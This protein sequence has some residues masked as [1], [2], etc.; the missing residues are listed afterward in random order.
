MSEKNIKKCIVCNIDTE[1]Q[2][3]NRKEIVTNPVWKSAV[4]AYRFYDCPNCGN[5]ISVDRPWLDVMCY[6]IE[7]M[8]IYLQ[9]RDDKTKIV[10]FGLV[11]EYQRHMNGPAD[12]L[13]LSPEDL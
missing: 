7:K 6:D 10:F 3:L 13:F 2:L 1:P 11:R 9:N 12:I 4:P 8:R 5:Y